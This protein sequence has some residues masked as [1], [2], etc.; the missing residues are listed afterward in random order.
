MYVHPF[1][2]LPLPLS[3]LILLSL[4]NQ[5]LNNQLPPFNLRMRHGNFN[6]PSAGATTAL[7]IINAPAVPTGNDLAQAAIV[8]VPDFD[9][10]VVEDEDIRAVD[11]D[12]LGLADKFHDYTAG[13]VAVFV[14]VDGAFFIAKQEFDI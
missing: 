1:P 11:G 9:K 3:L 5:Q 10:V 14:D 2:L 13:D 4:I 12:G 7:G 8:G 6:S